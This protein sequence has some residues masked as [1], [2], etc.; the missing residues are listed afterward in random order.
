MT[1]LETFVEVLARLSQGDGVF[2]SD[3]ELNQWPT[4]AIKALKTQKLLTKAPPANSVSCPGC[5]EACVMMVEQ[6]PTSSGTPAFFIV[7]DKRDDINRVLIRDDQLTLWQASLT[8]IARF[9]GQNLSLRWNGTMT[10]SG[11]ALQIGIMK[12]KKKSQMLCLRSEK[13]IYLVAG[14][15]QFPLAEVIEFK[16]GRYGLD[17][18]AITQLVDTTTT[19]DARYTPA[20]ARREARKLETSERYEAWNREY[21]KLKKTKPGMS[22][23]W[24]AI[25]ISRMDIADGKSSETIR[26]RLD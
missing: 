6:V 19:S 9:I 24:Y 17:V 16:G 25:K 4:D 10:E 11:E 5:E 23:T 1:P 20:N 2:I 7:C 21:R 26:K 14:S 18:D 22:K 15:N 3:Q 8:N 13:E 12:G